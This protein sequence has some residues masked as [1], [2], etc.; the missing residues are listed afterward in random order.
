MVIVKTFL[1]LSEGTMTLIFMVV[2][3]YWLRK[4]KNK[5]G[6]LWSDQTRH[7]K[8]PANIQWNTGA[9][10]PGWPTEVAET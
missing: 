8:P 6:S 10:Q 3:S 4:A 1:D 2:C 9:G 5:H 7:D